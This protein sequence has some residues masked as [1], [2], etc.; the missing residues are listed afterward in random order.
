MENTMK[1]NKLPAKTW[2]WLKMNDT[3]LKVCGDIYP[4]DVVA[5]GL[6]ESAMANEDLVGG[7]MACCAMAESAGFRGIETGVGR[8]ADVIFDAVPVKSFVARGVADSAMAD[9]AMAGSAMADGAMAECHPLYI[10]ISPSGGAVS[11]GGIDVLAEEGKEI[12]VIETFGEG[13]PSGNGN[14]AGKSDILAFRSRFDIKKDARVRLVQVFMQGPDTSI[15]NDVGSVCA[16]NARFDVLQIFIGMG[17]LYNGVRTDL[18]GKKALTNMDIGYLG[19]KSQVIDVN[20]IINHLGKKT[21][22]NIQVDGSLKDAAQKTFRGTIDFKNGASGAKGAETENVLLLGEDVVNRTIPIIL[23]A[24]ENVE[25]THGATIGELDDE[26]MFYF[27]SR[28]IDMAAAEDMMTRG[29]MEV[30][31]RKI[32]DAATEKKV[33]KQLAEVM[34]YDRSE[35]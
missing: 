1:I 16:E 11:A 35:V 13:K 22:C 25:G 21:E 20:L 10:N 32:Q 4:C 19:Q 15:I 17:N 12:T 3:S 24:E 31:Y 33:E 14:A 5:G 29:R 30:L 23:C 7:A 28:G 6:A 34:A 9:G 26:T 18:V 2:Y 27:A 8:D